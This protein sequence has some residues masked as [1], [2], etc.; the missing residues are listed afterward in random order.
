MAEHRGGMKLGNSGEDD[1]KE[2]VEATVTCP[3]KIRVILSDPDAT[4][5]SSDEGGDS[6]RSSPRRIVHE[7]V[8]GVRAGDKDG[9][10]VLKRSDSVDQTQPERKRFRGVRLR[11][12]GKWCSEIRDPF[13]K[14]RIWLGTYETAEEALNV[15]NAKKEEFRFRE[16]QSGQ[17]QPKTRTESKKQSSIRVSK[18]VNNSLNGE[19]IVKLGEDPT[20]KLRKGVRRT[21]S[22]RW[23]RDPFKKSQVWVGTFDTEE[24]ASNGFES[25]K[26]EVGL[27]V[28]RFD[29]ECGASL[30]TPKIETLSFTTTS[31]AVDGKEENKPAFRFG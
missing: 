22:G 14:K 31:M 23:N 18:G 7:I 12:W 6:E 11:K 15:Y 20:R 27:K 16:R 9:D 5:S 28:T 8:L 24:E 25:K 19:E 29:S 17:N 4:D 1:N 10:E 3:R 30:K 2:H 13:S 21:K 26:L